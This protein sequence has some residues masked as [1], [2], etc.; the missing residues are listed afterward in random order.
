M[1]SLALL[2]TDDSPLAPLWDELTDGLAACGN[3][4][5]LIP[6]VWLPGEK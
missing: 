5:L 4:D 3:I 6:L 2:V 1:P